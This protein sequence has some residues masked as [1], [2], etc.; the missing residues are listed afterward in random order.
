MESSSSETGP[1]EFSSHEIGHNQ[2]RL[3]EDLKSFRESNN[4]RLIPFCCA[5][6]GQGPDSINFRENTDFRYLSISVV[7]LFH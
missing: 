1:L 6:V 4:Q 5:Q 3:S 7:L 2:E